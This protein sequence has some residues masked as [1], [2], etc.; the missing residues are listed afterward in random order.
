MKHAFIDQ[1]SNLD[2]I[3]HRLDP[4]AKLISCMLLL[5][6]LSWTSL[7]GPLL[8]IFALLIFSAALSRVPPL[9]LLKRTLI[10]LPLLFLLG[11]LVYLSFILDN[12]GAR[13]FFLQ[14]QGRRLFLMINKALLAVMLLSLLTSVTPFR[15]L[16]WAM[17]R[18]RLP[19]IVTTLSILL[20]TYL[21]ILVDETQRTMRARKSRSGKFPVRRLQTFAYITGTIFLRA[22]NRAD[23]IYKAML[24]RGFKGDF[25]DT[26]AASWRPADGF[27][28]ALV[29]L[30]VILPGLIWTRLFP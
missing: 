20:Y 21:F 22:L 15:R 1:Y 2:S 18:L 25:P 4:R 11:L 26:R 17:R 3:L 14:P 7:F 16:L 8:L 10:V 29:L 12:P 27:S 9:H 28:L 19:R 6:F 23:T 5:L 13:D 24:A 30:L